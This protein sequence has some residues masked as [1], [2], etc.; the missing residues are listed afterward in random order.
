MMNQ[1]QNS[2]QND[3]VKYSLALHF[4]FWKIW[5]RKANEKSLKQQR[6]IIKVGHFFY[7]CFFLHQVFEQ[8]KT[9]KRYLA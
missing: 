4:H 9:F 7:H 2:L 3:I 5:Y 6:K 1:E 8:N